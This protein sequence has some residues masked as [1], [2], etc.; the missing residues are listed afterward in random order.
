MLIQSS[1]LTSAWQLHAL[2]GITVAAEIKEH[3]QRT[4][5]HLQDPAKERLFDL[6]GRQPR[7]DRIV[8][9]LGDL[10]DLVA[11]RFAIESCAELGDAFH[12]GLLGSWPTPNFPP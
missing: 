8:D 2:T 10:S 5:A 12:R 4:A 3:P 11:K 9:K 7:M 1:P 6:M